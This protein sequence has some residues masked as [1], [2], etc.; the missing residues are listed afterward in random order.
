MKNNKTNI[1]DELG[2]SLKKYVSN[3]ASNLSYKEIKE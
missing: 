1:V 3:V 2:G